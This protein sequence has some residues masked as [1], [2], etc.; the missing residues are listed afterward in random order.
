MP[1][2]TNPVV[3]PVLR[4][5][6]TAAFPI[7]LLAVLSALSYWLGVVA[8][9][10][11][12]DIGGR[13]RH[14]P[15]TIIRQFD[16]VSYDEKGN[17]KAGLRG[18][19]LQHFPDDESSVIQRPFMRRFSLSGEPSTVSANQA[20]VNSDG[21]EVDL[22]GDVKAFRPAQGGKAAITLTAPHM[23][24]LVDEERARTP[25]FAR[26]QQGSSW[27]SGTGFDADNVTQVFNFHGNVTGTYKR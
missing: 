4:D 12:V 21:S 23:H 9:A 7:G 1:W 27:I 17:R 6:F 18:T 11:P 16:G 2:K 15:D 20:V 22:T 10:D 3:Q 25:G 5:I 19:E 13:F 8:A 14:D 26:I 24:V